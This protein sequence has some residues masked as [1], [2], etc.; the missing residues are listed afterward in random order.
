MK[1]PASE[2]LRQLSNLNLD[3]RRR[4]DYFS[5]LPGLLVDKPARGE[6]KASA[7]VGGTVHY[8]DLAKFTLDQI[9]DPAS[10]REFVYP[11]YTTW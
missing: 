4:L 2:R 11:S 5:T 10:A 8:P 3:Y 7:W 9:Q 6:L 1:L